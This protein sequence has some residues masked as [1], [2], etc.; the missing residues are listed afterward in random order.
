MV[1]DP[2]VV[3][4][5]SVAE[6]SVVDPRLGLLRWHGRR[7]RR[8]HRWWHTT[9]M[10]AGNVHCGVLVVIVVQ[11]WVVSGSHSGGGGS[12]GVWLTDGVQ[13]LGGRI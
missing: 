11:H 4:A 13:R 9:G 2:S 1:E 12:G 6:T 10:N 7:W 3:L 5:R 8:T